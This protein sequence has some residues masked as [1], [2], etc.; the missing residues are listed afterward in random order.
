MFVIDRYFNLRQQVKAFMPVCCPIRLSY[1]V[2]RQTKRS[3]SFI[4]VEIQLF[5]VFLL[6]RD[7]IFV[8]AFNYTCKIDRLKDS[9]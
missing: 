6:P 5:S 4:F 8:F 7:V 2:S 3:N 9:F 1:S